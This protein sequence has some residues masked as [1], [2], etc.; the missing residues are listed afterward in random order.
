MSGLRNNSYAKKNDSRTAAFVGHYQLPVFFVLTF[1]WSW[2]VFFLII[3]PLGWVETRQAQIMFA[4]GPLIGAA[5]VTAVSGG[6]LR[7]WAAQIHPRNIAPRWYFIALITPLVLTDGSRILVWLTGAPVTVA[8]IT[9]LEFL[10][11][12]TITLVIAGSLEEFGWR[13]FAQPRIQ[14]RWSALTAA[15]LIGVIWALWHFPLVYGGAGAGYDAGA[16]VGF[17]IGLPVFSVAMAW[18]YNSTKGG[19]LFVM[20]FHAMI[21]APSPLQIANSAPTWANT[22]GGLGQ[23]VLLL[24]VPLILFLY[25]GRNYLAASHPHPPIPG[26]R[27]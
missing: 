5:V 4:W 24:M 9:F 15:I 22:V 3:R 11:K 27:P 20:L 18:I 2:G 8:D 23:L 19:L 1:M 16:F 7:E 21:N 13:G 6:S 14:E 12:F 25:Y 10:S 26:R 17:L